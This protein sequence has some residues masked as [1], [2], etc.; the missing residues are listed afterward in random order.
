MY[1]RTVYGG[2]MIH[3]TCLVQLQILQDQLSRMQMKKKGKSENGKKKNYEGKK[4]KQY[5]EMCRSQKNGTICKL[6]INKNV[7]AFIK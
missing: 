1:N 7:N 4:K 6:S 3:Q 2:L 5:T